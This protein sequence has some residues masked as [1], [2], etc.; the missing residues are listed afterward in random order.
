MKDIIF[1]YYI[2]IDWSIENI[3]IARITEESN[4]IIPID[5]PSDMT[6]MKI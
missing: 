5:L 1:N 3:G 2:A 4:R 6:E